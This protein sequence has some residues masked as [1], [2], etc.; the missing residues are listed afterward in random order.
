MPVGPPFA[1]L[2]TP[3]PALLGIQGY[4][5]PTDPYGKGHAKGSRAA[6]AL[7]I[8]FER[9]CWGR[10]SSRPPGVCVVHPLPWPPFHEL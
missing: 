8:P 3:S 4:E 10:I 1:L 7:K 6:L 9:I 5:F 2:S